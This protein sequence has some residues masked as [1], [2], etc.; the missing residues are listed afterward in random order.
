MPRRCCRGW[1]V[2]HGHATGWDREGFG[3]LW[4]WL[5]LAQEP[6]ALI[7]VW[8]CPTHPCGRVARANER[9]RRGVGARLH[10]A[11][12]APD[13][14][15]RG[16]GERGTSHP[17]LRGV[18]MVPT[19][20]SSI[21]SPS[22]HGTAGEVGLRCPGTTCAVGPGGRV[23]VGCPRGGNGVGG[24]AAAPLRSRFPFPPLPPVS[25]DTAVWWKA[26]ESSDVCGDECCE[27]RI[28]IRRE[29]KAFE[30]QESETPF[31]TARPPELPCRQCRGPSAPQGHPL[32][33]PCLHT[34]VPGEKEGLEAVEFPNPGAGTARGQRMSLLLGRAPFPRV[35]IPPA[36]PRSRGTLP[37]GVS[38]CKPTGGWPP[39]SAGQ[40]AGIPRL[41]TPRGMEVQLPSILLSTLPTPRLRSRPQP[42]LSGLSHGLCFSPSH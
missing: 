37:T 15:G 33:L 32:P 20:R 17:R 5:F 8:V 12:P 36:L 41:P 26:S 28:K 14:P 30:E 34:G 16:R 24:S 4:L 22:P 18:R 31:V 6:S 10:A 39:G 42:D 1:V 9:G 19:S 13:T 25:M 35:A 27:G 2:W 23:T 38:L 7:G 29:G 3:S 40:P 11:A 21:P